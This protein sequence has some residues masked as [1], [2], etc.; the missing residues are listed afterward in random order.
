MLTRSPRRSLIVLLCFMASVLLAG[1][2]TKRIKTPAE[3]LIFKCKALINPATGT[4]LE[5]SFIETNG[6]R[7]L[8]TG[9]AAEL[10]GSETAKVVDYGDKYV[11]P[12]LIDTHGHLYGGVTVRYTTSPLI[13][14]FFLAAGVTSIGDPGS[15]DPGGD[16]AMRNRIDSGLYAG[17]RY[18]LAGEYLEMAPVTVGW[19][20]P[21][22]TPEEA[23]LK[24]DHSAAEGI[25]AIKIYANMSGDVMQ[26]AV[27]EAHEH[28]LRVWAHIGA[29]TYKQA[30]SMGVDQLYHGVL[31][32]SDT[33]SPSITQRDF[34]AWT[35]ATSALDL[36][37]PE[38]LDMLR[39]VAA[40]K[41][42][43]TP[44]TVVLDS[45]L[46]GKMEE[47]HME[48]QKKYYAPQAWDMLVKYSHQF[49]GI[50][51]EQLRSNIA[52]NIE[53]VRRAHDAGCILS[54]GT[55][56][57]IP[58]IL[59]GVSL[60][61]EMELFSESGLAPMEILKAATVNGA[62]A[63]G[64]SDQLGTVEAGKLADFVVLDRNPLENINNVRSV[65]RVVKG[66]VIYDPQE[67]LKPLEGKLY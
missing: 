13:P 15:M 63:L 27:D 50:K 36:S 31:A 2:Q 51:E 52:K 64:R 12:G 16:L 32:M 48:E 34:A 7:I 66:G 28:G 45:L 11:I 18:F 58:A 59:P 1:A 60:W 44:T 6:G 67:L 41:V 9:K 54:T 46:P 23:R 47:H 61:R 37:K 40:Q 55:D 8:R 53:F 10:T 30:I 65:S 57:V 17:P 26:A 29:V 22:A 25:S 49:P 21:L 4:I 33:R 39:Q 38:I 19:M 3:H 62:Y 42:V 5:N 14:I 56:L 24:V 35:D 43:L 20:S